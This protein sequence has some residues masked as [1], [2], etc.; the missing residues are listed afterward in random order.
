MKLVIR[1]AINVFALLIVAYLI[2]GFI[3]ADLTS[4]VVAAVVIGVVNTF[5]RPLLQL[6]A[7]PISIL[8]WGLAAFFINVALLYLTS[9]IVPGFEIAN[10]VTAILASVVLSLVSWFLNK[11]ARE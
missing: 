10:F 9:M 5:I 8:T 7:L 3:L 4:A 1:L 11:L 6:I 2:P